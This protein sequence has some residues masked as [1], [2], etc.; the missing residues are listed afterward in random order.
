MQPVHWV[1]A[2]SLLL[3]GCGIRTSY[4]PLNP[5]PRELRVRT[6]EQVEVLEAEPRQPYVE[7]GTIEVRQ[8]AGNH[9]DKEQL[10]DEI[11]KVG[12]Q[13]GCE[14]VRI[15]GPND[16]NSNKGF[17]AACI[18]FKEPVSPAEPASVPAPA[19]ATAPQEA[20]SP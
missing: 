1:A 16:H 8:M 6:P 4:T 11:R 12:A 5:S 3:F 17:Q 7:I 15:V 13:R 19:P 2:S 10:Y 18:V 20:T 14:A 9:A